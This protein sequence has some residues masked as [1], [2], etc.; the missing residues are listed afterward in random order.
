MSDT[1]PC[2]QRLKPPFDPQCADPK[3]VFHVCT[4]QGA[5]FQFEPQMSLMEEFRAIREMLQPIARLEKQVSLL[6]TMDKRLD[7]LMRGMETGTPYTSR[8]GR[9]RSYTSSFTGSEKERARRPSTATSTCSSIDL[10][11]L[12]VGTNDSGNTEASRRRR[13]SVE[14]L[15]FHMNRVRQ[16]IWTFLENSE[17]SG[18]ARCFHSL[19]TVIIFASVI[20]SLLHTLEPPPVSG[21]TAAILETVCDSL[22]AADVVLR[23]VVCP[24]RRSFFRSLYNFIDI[25]AAVPLILRISIGFHIPSEE[26]AYALRCVLILVVPWLRLLKILRRFEYLR[27]LYH[28]GVLAAE[29]LAVPLFLLFVINVFFSGLVYIVEP[30][31]NIVSVPHAM[32]LV[33]VTMSTVGFGETVPTTPA[34][35]LIVSLLVVGGV[36]YMALPISIVGHAFADVWRRRDEILLMERTRDRLKAWG[37]T[38]WDMNMIFRR[39][40]AN[41]D[42]VLDADEFRSMVVEMQLGLSDRRIFDLFDTFDR[43]RSGSVDRIEFAKALFPENYLEI[44]EME[45]RD[46]RSTVD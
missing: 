2:P 43:N 30:R 36:M 23:F 16:D 13:V 32:W 31:E 24:N 37:Y 26:E 12:Q 18:W 21:L 4:C 25:F 28:A 3:C 14:I 35:Y 11:E 7:E 17:S 19:V 42:D 1:R 46:S 33:I 8:I 15:H 10:A 45:K 38:A 40:D 41:G 20:L 27:L 9:G 6:P 22:F 39:F 5:P 34:G 29:A 44:A